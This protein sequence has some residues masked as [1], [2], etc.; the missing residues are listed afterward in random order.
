MEVPSLGANSSVITPEGP[1]VAVIG[2]GPAGM[3]FLRQLEMER[4][5]LEALLSLGDPNETQI[6]A[7]LRK[8]PR[9]TVFEKD[10]R[11][12]GLWQSKSMKPDERGIEGEGMYDGMWINA[13]KEVFEFAE[14]TF[15]EH[16]GKPMPS[17]I[18][19]PDVLG[20]I[21]GATKD[22][23]E[24]HTNAG[25]ILFDTEV[26]W[27]DFN[28][29]TKKFS[30]ADSD[31]WDITRYFDKVVM[32]TG[33]EYRPVI[34]D[35]EM[36]L[37]K[38]SNET[39][40][41]I[42]VFDK[43][44]VHSSQIKSLGGDIAGKNFLFI[45]ASY[46]AEDLALS[47]IKRGANHIYVTSRSHNSYPISE[48]AHW[49]MDKLTHIYRAEIKEV[50]EGNKL[51]IGR[52][53]FASEIE[54][55]IAKTYYNQTHN[56]FLL[57][58][59]D[60]VIFCT[61]YHINEEITAKKLFGYPES[62][63]AVKTNVDASHWP[64][65]YDP[66][67]FDPASGRVLPSETDRNSC[68]RPNHDN[69]GMLRADPDDYI[70]NLR[71][72]SYNHHLVTN[73]GFFWTGA[74]YDTPLLNLD[75]QA[76]FILKVMTGDIPT[77]DTEEE[78]HRLRSRSMAEWLRHSWNVRSLKDPVFMNAVSMDLFNVS[79]WH[80]PYEW[81]YSFFRLF[82]EAREAGHPAGSFIFEIDDDDAEEEEPPDVDCFS[83][84]WMRFRN[85]DGPSG[86]A[87]STWGFTD[88]GVSFMK[89][90]ACSSLGHMRIPW[91]TNETFRDQHFP[92][93]ESVYT[94]TKSVPFS[95]LWM[96]IDDVLG[97]VPDAEDEED[98]VDPIAP[99]EN[100]SANVAAAEGGCDA[101]IDAGTRAE[102]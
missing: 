31:E 39:T 93:Y 73:T 77:P 81:G 17:Y 58:G 84:E 57:E 80:R 67:D 74:M 30:L 18:T 78:M 98:D 88:R 7:R 85:V 87:D 10:S 92:D 50:L 64:N 86:S 11:C 52:M 71:E 36:K 47:F 3:L 70:D 61:G 46:S 44:V 29:T 79:D 28:E 99:P 59:I 42:P 82:S 100:V 23:I 14:Y 33:T 56:D 83:F 60:A 91:G 65:I 35:R 9:P 72:G 32:A 37:L 24:F 102:L 25:S 53:E 89:Q 75:I 90:Y 16:F 5:R 63:P 55:D 95:K 76:A 94:G 4:S 13:P 21:E 101:A 69:N 19:R 54:R 15:D 22:A 43:P 20:Y 51:R 48:T 12:G 96:D 45:G 27:I 34:P 8:L 62:N 68:G 26:N 97:D 40:G 2:C 38:G 49:P 6:E 41:T 1:T 66:A